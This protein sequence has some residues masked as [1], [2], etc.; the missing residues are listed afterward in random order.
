MMLCF[1]YAVLKTFKI[2]TKNLNCSGMS[3]WSQVVPN[4][5]NHWTD[6]LKIWHVSTVWTGDDMGFLV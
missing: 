3:S 6:L 5:L 1:I 2:S 4:R